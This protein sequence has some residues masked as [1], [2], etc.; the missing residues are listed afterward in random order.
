MYF[1]HHR[2]KIPKPLLSVLSGKYKCPAL[3]TSDVINRMYGAFVGFIIGDSVG[4]YL[5]FHVHKIDELVLKALLM[6]GGGTYNTNPGQGTADTELAFALAY[7]LIEGNGIYKANV[8]A[9]HYA[10]WLKSK[11]FDT[12]A[13]V[14]IA[15]KACREINID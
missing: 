3:D 9:K 8:I 13:L 1:S 15:L 6:N 5:A 7:G 2:L 4:S 11:P 10:L 14:L 12:S